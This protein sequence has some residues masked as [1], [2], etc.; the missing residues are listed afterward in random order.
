[1]IQEFAECFIALTSRKVHRENLHES[2]RVAEKRRGFYTAINTTLCICSAELAEEKKHKEIFVAVFISLT[3]PSPR[4][5]LT[6]PLTFRFD[7]RWK[8]FY[9]SAKFVTTSFSFVTKITLGSF[10][11]ISLRLRFRAGEIGSERDRTR[12]YLSSSENQCRQP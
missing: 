12:D 3:Q 11:K 7:I 10:T 2:S 4:F 5:L 9:H 6:T 8:I 1:M